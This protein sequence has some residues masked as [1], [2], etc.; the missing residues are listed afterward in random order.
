M[1]FILFDTPYGRMGLVEESGAIVRLYLPNEGTPRIAEHETPLLVKGKRQLMEYFDGARREFDLPLRSEGTEFR[2]KVWKAL[3]DIPYGA[4]ISYG[5][6]AVNVGNPKAVRAVG[7]ANHHNPI[8]I[9]IPC[10]RVVGSNGT[11]T[12]YGGG[13]EL[14]RQLLDLEQEGG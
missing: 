8:P 6:L 11:L 12:G 5:Q 3:L 9:L 14:K 2:K 10:H 7:Q 1:D 13:M 4:T